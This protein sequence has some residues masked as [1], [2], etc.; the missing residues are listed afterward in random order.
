MAARLGS[1]EEHSCLYKEKRNKCV[2]DD[3]TSLT[4][5]LTQI[6]TYFLNSG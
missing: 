5:Y 2:P 1:F 3:E 6:D 4:L